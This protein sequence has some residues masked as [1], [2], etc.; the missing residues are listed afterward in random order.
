MLEATNSN[1]KYPVLCASLD[2]G[3]PFASA[4]ALTISIVYDAFVQNKKTKF[5][6]T[7]LLRPF[8]RKN[9]MAFL[10]T[11]FLGL[12]GLE[13]NAQC[14]VDA[15][16]IAS[17]VYICQG[18][19]ITFTNTSAGSPTF[20]SWSENTVSFSSSASPT[21]AFPTPGN[22]LIQF[23]ASNGSC[24]DSSSTLVVVAPSM[25]SSVTSVDPTCFGGSDG[26][27]N[28]TPSAGTRNI[29]LDNVRSGSDFTTANSL[30]GAGY[31]GGITVE[32]WVKPRSTWTS[33]DGLF[34]SFNF[35]T[36]TANRFFVGYNP[37]LQ[38][39][40]YYDDNSGNQ[41]QDGAISPRGSWYHVVVTISSGN[42]MSLYVD[43]VLRK[44]RAT[45][46]DWIPQV[47]D[48][49][50]I[51]QEWDLA[52]GLVPSQ[53]F[54]GNVDEMRVWNAV[55]S[56]ATIASN[57]NGCM[58]VNPSH[59]NW[60]NLV[61]YYSMNE[62]SGTFVFDRSGNGHH[63]TR[64]GGTG[65]GTV[66]ETDWGCFNA[67][68]GYAYNWS[69]GAMIEDPTGLSS[70]T[71]TCTI[72]DG[73]GCTRLQNVTLNDPAPVVVTTNPAT[74]TAI[75]IG[76]STSI[77]ASGA[78]TYTWS[79]SGGL[80]GTTGATVTA[81]PSS[82]S[83]YLVTG[84][85][86]LGC[87]D[88]VSIQVV[89]N[90]LPTAAISG[91]NT[92][93]TGDTANLLASGGTSYV[94]SNGPS[95]ASN[96]VNPTSNTTYTVTVTDANTCQDTAQ[97]SV[98]VNALPTVSFTGMDT[99]CNG[100]TTTITASGGTSYAWSNG[101]SSAGQDLNPSTTTSYTVTVTDANT[102]E[103][104]GSVTVVV[105]ALPVLSFVG[106][107][108]ICD[109]DSTQI[110]VSGASTYQWGFGPTTSMVDLSPSTTTSF[111]VAGT[112]GNGC[113]ASDTIEIVVNAL[114]VA[115]ITGADSICAGDTTSLT[116]AGGTSYVWSTTAMT[117]SIDVAPTAATTYTVTVSDVN[118]CEAAASHPVF[119]NALPS[120]LIAGVDTICPGDTVSLIASGGLSYVWSTS[121]TTFSIDVN[122]STNTTYTVTATDNNGC[123]GVGSHTLNMASVP[124]A[125]ISPAGGNVMQ[126]T[127]G[128]A[129]YQWYF[130]GTLIP[131]ATM[132]TYT[133]TQNG[134]Y[135]VQVTNAQGCSG[136]S[137]DYPFVLVGI[138]NPG[139]SGI[140]LTVYPNPNNGQFVM[141]LE[142]DHG[143]AVNMRIFDLVG[144]QV[145]S[146]DAQLPYGEFKQSVDLSNLSKGTY[147]IQILTEEGRMSR[148]VVIE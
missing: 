96:P 43:G 82:T 57:Y 122:P 56:P 114:P 22:Y 35:G 75:C 40:V 42:L 120:I 126:A 135:T 19:S 29:C 81:N 130:N 63:G 146:R 138:S 115:S 38:K 101:P 46:S 128:F 1:H 94:W 79:P 11:A 145:W 112:D 123:N 50:S 53:H 139:L 99:I 73:A 95:V 142:L 52:P 93:C 15:Q 76:N 6:T 89:V 90:A 59:P 64:V 105:N 4:I 33:G 124:V 83:T 62:G 47:G 71:Y 116:A 87:T 61:A 3:T 27:A 80:S 18:Q 143:L 2:F 113:T 118:G 121:E 134:D 28:L 91:A 12:I 24:T 85:S 107:D 104:S 49:F 54:D 97:I 37:G 67:G 60:G 69:N 119:V 17:N 148:K 84:T 45:N 14:P 106:T 127:A 110:T 48:L 86:S 77:T 117:T 100:D 103:N 55:L 23:F 30:T 108:T 51:G 125:V 141:Q 137:V 78:S 102:C 8:L 25:G 7:Q 65:Y 68:T 9:W 133:G 111:D 41:F 26:S 70:G 92:I 32:T 147:L 58:N 21:R 13:A 74:S 10:L 132:D 72:T 20:F 98:N 16:F 5:M 109:G 34:A 144:K 131:G 129:T 140:D 44:T 31:S 36:G 88:T 39:F 66:P 136:T